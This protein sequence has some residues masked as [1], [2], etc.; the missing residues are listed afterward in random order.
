MHVPQVLVDAV[1]APQE[2]LSPGAQSLEVELS[3]LSER[4]RALQEQ[5]AA[6]D[7][8]EQETLAGL[9]EG[10]IEFVQ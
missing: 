5:L 10:T 1:F 4:R 3:R 6:L 8:L 9:S 7:E 2:D